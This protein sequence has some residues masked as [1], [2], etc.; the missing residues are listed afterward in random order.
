M[1]RLANAAVG[2]EIL[3]KAK[4]YHLEFRVDLRASKEV[5][6]TYWFDELLFAV[7]PELVAKSS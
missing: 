5:I 1:W 7:F 2:L 4:M 6:G 3:N